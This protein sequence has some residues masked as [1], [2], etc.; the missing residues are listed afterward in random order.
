MV[1]TTISKH[2]SLTVIKDEVENILYIKSGEFNIIRV[3]YGVTVYININYLTLSELVE[4]HYYM[5][6][7]HDHNL[8]NLTSETY[9]K[10]QHILSRLKAY[11]YNPLANEED[12]VVGFLTNF[13][14]LKLGVRYDTSSEGLDELWARI[15]IEYL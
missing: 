3:E 6:F 7:Q 8:L 11:K 15:D 9:Y 2:G 1:T 10:L 12:K 14:D 4:N 13:S 5:T